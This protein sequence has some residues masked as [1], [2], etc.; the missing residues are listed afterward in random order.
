MEVEVGY[1]GAHDMFFTTYKMI[2]G[3]IDYLENYWV[4][5]ETGVVYDGLGEFCGIM[6]E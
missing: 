4:T 5:E 3:E 6:F 2:N 1:D